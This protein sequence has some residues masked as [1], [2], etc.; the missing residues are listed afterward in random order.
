[1]FEHTNILNKFSSPKKISLSMDVQIR[2]GFISKNSIN[3]KN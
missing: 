1:M 3:G 2:N